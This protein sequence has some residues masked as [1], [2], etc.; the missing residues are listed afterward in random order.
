MSATTG[1]AHVFGANINT[2]DVIAGKY[3]HRTIDLDELLP[4]LMENIRP[5][6][7]ETVAPGDFIVAGPNF[8]CGSSREQAPALIR[9]ARVAAVIAPSYARIF[10]RNAINVGL[11]VIEAPTDGIEDG[12]IVQYEPETGRILVPD[13]G[14]S[15]TAAPMPEDLRR[16][17]EAGGLLNFVRAGG[18]DA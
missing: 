12:D 15:A 6:F 11:H 1:R 4:H 7:A 2:D 8:G 5:G 17:V 13:K 3:K 9:H 14:W 10:F 18:F 16:L